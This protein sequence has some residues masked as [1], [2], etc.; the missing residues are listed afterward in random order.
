MTHL[1]RRDLG[2]ALL[3]ASLF[4]SGC[5]ARSSAGAL[6]PM[7]APAAATEASLDASPAPGAIPGGAAQT[8][9]SAPRSAPRTGLARPAPAPSPSGPSAVQAKEDPRAPKLDDAQKP[10]LVYEGGLGVRVPK[11]ELADRLEQAIDVAEAHGGYLVSRTDS[12]AQLRVPSQRF[13]AAL[14]DLGALGEV[15]RRSVAAQDVS[16]Q[17]HDLEVRLKNLESVR[18]RLEQFL[19]RAANVDEALRVGKELEGVVRQIDEAKG[20]MQ[21]LKTRAAYSLITLTLEPAADKAPVVATGDK[22][23]PT[24]PARPLRMPVK[25]LGAVGLDQLLSLE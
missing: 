16:E 3:L 12:G 5:A 11:A 18:A 25:W 4:A 13:R 22:P 14:K 24:P 8:P 15:T 7:A 9:A 10:L 2:V 21:Y 23:V 19:A 1:L 17:Y 20:R 6:A